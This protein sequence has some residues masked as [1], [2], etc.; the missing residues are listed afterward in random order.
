MLHQRSVQK[1]GV[2]RPDAESFFVIYKSVLILAGGG[3]S[4]LVRERAG[5]IAENLS[6]ETRS[7]RTSSLLRPSGRSVKNP[8][9]RAFQGCI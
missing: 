5:T 9:I 7:S 2:V 4:E 1:K 8:V 6:S 3:R